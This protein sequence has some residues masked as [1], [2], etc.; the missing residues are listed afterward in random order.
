M[1]VGEAALPS[2]TNLMEQLKWHQK[3]LKAGM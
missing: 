3:Q 2:T 1:Y